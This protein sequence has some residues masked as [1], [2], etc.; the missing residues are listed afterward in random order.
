MEIDM[1]SSIDRRI[2]IL[3][4][5]IAREKAKREEEA[6]A[7]GTPAPAASVEPGPP[8]A[9]SNFDAI[10]TWPFPHRYDELE[11]EYEKRLLH[12]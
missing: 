4:E 12:G 10:G 11:H 8:T 9:P 7:T 2:R 6:A 3:D 5:Q 1:E